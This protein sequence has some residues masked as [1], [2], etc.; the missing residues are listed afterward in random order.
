GADP[1]VGKK[2]AESCI[3]EIEQ[4]LDGLD[5]V[6]LTAGMGGGTGTGASP[7]VAAAAQ[8]MGI[9]TVGIVTRPFT[10]EG[11]RRRKAAENGVAEL[12]KNVDTLITIS[13]DKLLEVVKEGTSLVKAFFVADDI[14]RQGVQGISELITVPGVINLDYADV[15]TIMLGSGTSLMGVGVERGED[16]ARRAAL[17]A[18]SSPLL[19]CPMNGARGVIIN[20]TGG[21]GVSL[22]EVTAAAEVVSAEA[23]PDANIIFGAVLDPLASDEIK[24]TVI[25]T[26]FDRIPAPELQKLSAARER[27]G[28]PGAERALAV[29]AAPEAHAAPRRAEPLELDVPPFLK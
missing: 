21:P 6:F 9:L 5:M 26:G 24:V 13:N 19:E 10:F 16:R 14:L 12:E 3:A 23:A 17:A 11:R 25:A 27:S 4:L 18:I 15:R 7:V 20:V 8:E 22:R 29:V 28:S 1:E 2:A